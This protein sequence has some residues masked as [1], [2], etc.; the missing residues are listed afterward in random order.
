MKKL[1][2]I[3][4]IVSA[5]GIV[6]AKKKKAPDF[7]LFDVKN[8]VHRLSKLKGKV[9]VLNFFG[10][11]CPPCRAEIP[12]FVKAAKKYKKKVKF[13]G[14]LLDNPYSAFKIKKFIKDYKIK[15]PILKGTRKVV[16]DYGGIRGIPTTFI[17]D[18]NG[19]VVERH[20][21]FLSQD[22][23][24]ELI[25]KYLKYKK[26]KKVKKIKDNKNAR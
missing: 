14:I 5:L 2:I 6:Y 3:I 19:V 17:I 25:K 26:I 15:Y 18:K 16:M 12:G 11:W 10:T 1:L 7:S 23:L 22:R 9:V 13:I 21:G 8:K 4:I 20:I 24:E